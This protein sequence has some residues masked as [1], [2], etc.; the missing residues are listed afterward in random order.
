MQAINMIDSPRFHT[1]LQY[2]GHGQVTDKDIPGRTCL[3]EN[4]LET[5]EI[6]R[7]QLHEEMKVC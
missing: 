2:Y 4:I 7:Q 3:T 6:E 1:V 5:W